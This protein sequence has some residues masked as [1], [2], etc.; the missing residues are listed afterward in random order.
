MRVS[1]KK[2]STSS[3]RSW[4]PSTQPESPIRLKEVLPVLKKLVSTP[5]VNGSEHQLA[6][7]IGNFFCREGFK[8]DSIHTPGCGPTVLACREFQPAGPKLL[9]CG[10]IDTAEPTQG[11]KTPPFKPTVIG[12]SLYGLGS[13]DMKGGLAALMIA[14]RRL[15]RMKL[16]GSLL[17]AFT[18]DEELHSRGCHT[19]LRQ[20]KVRG[21]DAGISA[22]PTGI[23]K[24]EVGRRGR[25]VY[26]ITV[27]G[28]S[29]HIAAKNA[30]VNAVVEGS[31]AVSN[32]KKLPLGNWQRGVGGSVDVLAMS[33]GTE[34]LTVPN[35]CH[36]LIDRHLTIGETKTEALEQMLNLVRSLSSKAKFNVT[37]WKKPTPFMN[38]Y[39]LPKTSRIVNVVEQAC[40]RVTGLKP[41]RSVGLS[42][43]DENYLVTR[44]RIPTVTIGPRGGNE[45][46]AN[47]YV[48]L[49]SVVNAAN[50]YVVASTIFLGN[51]LS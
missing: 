4:E 34:F 3:K 6:S 26:D 32:L 43:G 19:L 23:D 28:V 17:L 36:L 8:T 12:G 51:Q 41:K 24:M 46:G 50:I 48:R 49:R 40:L 10:H 5:S 31:K 7:Y 2:P 15:S 45:H 44:A 39:M 47:E 14:A 22:E 33:G 35:T 37:F 20:G 9:L 25:V 1:E 38:P 42:S 27:Q 16:Q 21:V 29:S 18:S 11:W 13:S 30:G